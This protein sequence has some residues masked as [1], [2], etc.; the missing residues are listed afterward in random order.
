VAANEPL[1][2]QR[3]AGA[4]RV[5]GGRRRVGDDRR[6]RRVLVV[7]GRAQQQRPRG[8]QRHD[9]VQ[10]ADAQHP[11][12]DLRG[13]DAGSPRDPVAVGARRAADGGEGDPRVQRGVEQ[14][15]RAAHRMPER[16]HSRGV[17]PRHRAQRGVRGRGVG[18]HRGH[19]QPVLHEAM[20][21]GGE[22][23]VA[24]RRPS[25]DARGPA[26]AVLE[27]GRV[28]DQ[29]RHAAPRERG[30]EGLPPVAGSGGDLGLAQMPLRGM[31]VMDHDAAAGWPV[32]EQ[33]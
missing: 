27:A 12:D 10:V 23:V 1:V 26:P 16:A 11:G 32:R 15:R 5:V 9:V 19:Q 8:D 22:V 28:G 7:G 13:L 21:H 2:S 24:V 25:V 17:D 3:G 29:D 18:E 31:L 6:V 14:R 20:G 4:Q 30:T 33:Q